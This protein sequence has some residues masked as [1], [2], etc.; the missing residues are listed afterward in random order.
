[1]TSITIVYESGSEVVDLDDVYFVEEVGE[2][3]KD[4]R[5]WYSDPEYDDS[6]YVDYELGTIVEVDPET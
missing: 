4:I 6:D 1:M 5:I 3:Q 2:V